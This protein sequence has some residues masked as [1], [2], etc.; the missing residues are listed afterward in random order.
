MT[1]S[2]NSV[3]T[4]AGTTVPSY[5]NVPE[6][7]QWNNPYYQHTT[8]YGSLLS[9]P[10]QALAYKQGIGLGTLSN[11]QAYE[12]PLTMRE[13][14]SVLGNQLKTNWGNMS[15]GEKGSSILNSVGSVMNAYNAYKANKLAQDQFNF[16]KQAWQANFENQ[17]KMTNSQLEDRQKARVANN[18]I[19]SESVDSYMRRYGV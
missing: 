17:R 18:P 6:Y 5:L 19:Q 11:T 9:D 8:D 1:T 16:Q 13:K 2:L 7:M 3:L 12:S 4:T 10:R 14:A 15:L